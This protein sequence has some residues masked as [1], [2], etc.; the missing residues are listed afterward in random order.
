M[1][2]NLENYLQTV[3]LFKTSPVILLDGQQKIS[4]KLS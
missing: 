3:D 4:T 1:K 2:A